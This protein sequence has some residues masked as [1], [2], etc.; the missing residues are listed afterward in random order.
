MNDIRAIIASVHR[1]FG[2]PIAG[3]IREADGFVSMVWE[4][5]DVNDK[6]KRVG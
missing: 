6:P 4:W 1:E 2:G 3:V 5:D